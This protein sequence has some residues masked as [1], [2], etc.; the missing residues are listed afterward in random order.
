L[1]N[2]EIKR[3][4]AR[5]VRTLAGG[6]I[7]TL[8]VG[9][10]SCRI[11]G[12]VHFAMLGHAHA[13]FLTLDQVSEEQIIVVDM[14]G[15]VVEGSLEPPG[16]KYIH[17][18]IYRRRPDVQAIV[19]GHPDLSMAFGV[20]F[21]KII[22]VHHRAM[23]FHPEVPLLDYSG[24]IDTPE[25]GAQ[26]AEAIG[27]SAALLLRGH[28]VVVVGESLTDACVSAFSLEKNCQVLMMAAQLGTPVPL[29]PTGGKTRHTSVWN[30]Y[31]RKFDPLFD[32]R[33]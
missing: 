11:P 15:N 27:E 17:T 30:Y 23:Q 18:E 9:H 26:V 3:Q 28:G 1:D 31:V 13:K 20:A 10:V 2:T 22:P 8:T 25:L 7:L 21:R 5:A 19:H 32:G 6:E 33:P 29:Q 14:N 12:T 16:E 24:Q 4:V